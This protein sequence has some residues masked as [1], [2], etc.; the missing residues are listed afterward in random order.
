MASIDYAQIP[1]FYHK[2]IKLV[3]EDA[4]ESALQKHQQMLVNTLQNIEPAKWDFRYAP[5]K[6]SVKEVVQHIIDAE[7]IFCYRALTFARGDQNE[8][9]G[10]DENLY[11]ENSN[12]EKRS[13]LDLIEELKV[14]Q[15][16]SLLLFSSF[17]ESQLKAKGIANGKPIYVEGIGYII[18]GHAL[19]HRKILIEK[20]GAGQ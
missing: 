19:H 6:W 15:R 10:F 20:Y 4:L 1:E 5:G 8:L 16:S 11:A 14:V 9:P 18:I 17:S 7:R 3:N 12:A 2:Y 13:N